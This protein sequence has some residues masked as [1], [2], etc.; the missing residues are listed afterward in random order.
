NANNPSKTALYN[1][2][3]NNLNATFNKSLADAY[4][5]FVRDRA[6]THPAAAQLRAGENA[7][8]LSVAL[9]PNANAARNV[10][11]TSCARNVVSVAGNNFPPFSSAAITINP[12]GNL[13]VNSSG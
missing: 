3:D 6:L 8:G 1:L 11:V 4:L 10:D 5:A 13:P 2:L 12:T 7:N 9:F